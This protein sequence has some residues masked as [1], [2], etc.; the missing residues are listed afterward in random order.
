MVRPLPGGHPSAFRKTS[1]WRRKCHDRA[2]S[3]H[4]DSCAFSAVTQ[5]SLYSYRPLEEHIPA[6]HPL[7]KLRVLVDAILINMNDDFQ[8]LYSRRLRPSIVPERLLRARL[9]QTLFSVWVYQYEISHSPRSVNNCP[10]SVV[11][12]SGTSHQTHSS[13]IVPNSLTVA[14]GRNFTRGIERRAGRQ[15][16]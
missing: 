13:S 12:N 7:R 15:Y 6:A 5:H 10:K 8:A 11:E 2:A 9:I 16:C 14:R 1:G 3:A 4:A